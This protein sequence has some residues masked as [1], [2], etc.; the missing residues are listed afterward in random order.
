[1]DIALRN[2]AD[3]DVTAKD[4]VLGEWTRCQTCS[5][6]LLSFLLFMVSR[7]NHVEVIGVWWGELGVFNGKS[8]SFVKVEGHGCLS[9]RM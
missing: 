4:S 1:M 9:V 6:L 2:K 8:Q 5:M 7:T 3:T